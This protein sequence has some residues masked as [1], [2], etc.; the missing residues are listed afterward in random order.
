MHSAHTG[1][2]NILKIIGSPPNPSW[3]GRALNL[4]TIQNRLW[5]ALRQGAA[6]NRGLQQAWNAHGEDSFGFAALE[7]LEDEA[8]VYVRDAALKDRLAYWRVHLSA[9]A[10]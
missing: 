10:I 1:L 6:A 3:V 9:S 7:Q 2:I 5:F 8:L 4:E